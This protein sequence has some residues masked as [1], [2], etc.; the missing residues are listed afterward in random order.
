MLK[1]TH[2]AIRHHSWVNSVLKSY[3]AFHI[4]WMT[5]SYSTSWYCQLEVMKARLALYTDA[6][7]TLIFDNNDACSPKN[8]ERT[9]RADLGYHWLQH[10]TTDV[11]AYPRVVMKNK[12]KWE[13]SVL[14]SSH[15][16]DER[17]VVKSQINCLYLISWWRHHNT[18]LGSKSYIRRTQC[19]QNAVWWYVCCCC[20]TIEITCLYLYTISRPMCK[21]SARD[22]RL[23]SH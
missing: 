23:Q 20:Q 2:R 13:L 9:H 4:K 16:L 15:G 3:L 19:H 8:H 10:E 7:G 11:T 18:V 6:H 21:T 14:V 22:Y 5:K 1:K 12:T 17:A